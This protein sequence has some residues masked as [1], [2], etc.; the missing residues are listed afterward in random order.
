MEKLPDYGEDMTRFSAD[1]FGN[2]HRL[3]VAMAIRAVSEHEPHN[4]YKQALANALDLTDSEIEKH[5][6]DFKSIG[7]LEKDPDP[8][9]PPKKRGRGKPPTVL[10]ITDDKFWHCLDELGQR[11]RRPPP[12]QRDVEN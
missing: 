3:A 8:P 7:L 11:F 6:R 4:L 10:R 2:Q 1:L 5:F 12:R 9:R